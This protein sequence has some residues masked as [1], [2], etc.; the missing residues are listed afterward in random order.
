M[1]APHL[2]TLKKPYHNLTIVDSPSFSHHDCSLIIIIYSSWQHPLI[3]VLS[4]WQLPHHSLI[5]AATLHS[6]T[7]IMAAPP[8]FSNHGS[9]PFI[10]ILSSWQQ[11]FILI[12]SSWQHPLHSHTFIMAATLQSHTLIIKGPPS[13]SSNHGGSPIILSS[14]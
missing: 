2:Y 7:P 4:S 1:A 3:L 5:M 13:F 6:N 12:L 14:L 11:P 10:I 9:T 8:S